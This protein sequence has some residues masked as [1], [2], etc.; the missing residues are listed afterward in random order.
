[1]ARTPIAATRIPEALKAIKQWVCWRYETRDGK[2]TKVPYCA[3]NPRRRADST[4]PATWADFEAALSAYATSDVDGVG[5]VFTEQD[6]IVGIDLD[7]CVSEGLIEPWAQQVIQRFGSYCEFTPSGTGVH[8]LVKGKLPVGRRRRGQ[9]EMYESGRYFTVTG[10]VID[11]AHHEIAE[12]NGTLEAWHSEL[13][14]DIGES[15]R[16]ASH[17]VGTMGFE[18]DDSGLIDRAR[19]SKNGHKFALLWS[20]DTQQYNGDHSAADM[21]LCSML[22]FWTGGDSMRMDRLFRGSGLYR[23]KW[24]ERRGTRSYGEI[25][26]ERAIAR[27]KEFYQPGMDDEAVDVA[28]RTLAER[29]RI[30]GT[31][32]PYVTNVLEKMEE[33]SEDPIRYYVAPQTMAAVLTDGVGNWPKSA[34]GMMFVQSNHPATDGLPDHRCVRFLKSSNALHAWIHEVA[35]LHFAR[36]TH[37]LKDG[38]RVSLVTKG[39][40]FE[41]VV[42]MVE[43]YSSVEMLPHVPKVDDIYYWPCN[44]PDSDGTALAELLDHLNPETETDRALMLAALMTPAWGGPPGTR[45]AFVFTS[46]HGR[47]S[48]K[49]KTVELFARIWGGAVSIGEDEDWEQVKTRL[50]SDDSFTRRIVIIDNIKGRLSRGGLEAAITSHSIDGRRLYVGQASRPNMITWYITANSPDLS[51]DLAERSV[52]IKVGQPQHAAAWTAWSEKF[53]A[54][55]RADVIA[56]LLTILR[57]DPQFSISADVSD[58]WRLWQTS[59]LSRVPG[60]NDLARAIIDARPEVDADRQD[61]EE[62][63]GVIRKVVA[64]MGIDPDAGCALI[65]TKDLHDVFVA[66]GLRDRHSKQGMTTGWIKHHLDIEPLRGC[67]TYKVIKIAGGAHRMWVWIGPLSAQPEH[68]PDLELY[69]PSYHGGN[70]Q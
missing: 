46:L 30:H 25:T 48:G 26:I 37:A 29:D 66:Q 8:I 56:D 27:C 44:L 53:I 42:S 15:K 60:G 57:R 3:A 58:R 21:A 39:E 4:D 23:D 68:L 34:G 69:R 22:A 61:A 18:G 64:G 70:E 35:D 14:A 32:R 38:R 43:R 51:R 13:F 36:A 63:A 17:A 45:P 65:H 54:T 33:D 2:A 52:I 6:P 1:M 55:R 16:A 67:L 62:I 41:N 31:A 50:L 59:I 24:G 5:F 9:I 12:A 20:G 11:D 19:R 40:F 49:T 7:K 28:I 47:G 10:N